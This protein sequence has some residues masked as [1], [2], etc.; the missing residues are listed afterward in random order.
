MMKNER[1]IWAVC[2]CVILAVFAFGCGNKP[3][4]VPGQNPPVE[5][6]DPVE[7]P[8]KEDVPPVA[9]VDP[10]E[11]PEEVPEAQVNTYSVTLYYANNEYI[12]TGNADLI[13]VIPFDTELEIPQDA[14]PMLYLLD[15]LKTVPG[16]ESNMA[17][18]INENIS[19]LDVREEWEDGV[20][21]YND[22][23]TPDRDEMV[24]CVNVSSEGLGGGSLTEELFITQVVETLMANGAF[25]ISEYGGP[26]EVQFLVDGQVADTLMGH[27]DARDT[28]ESIFEW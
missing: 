5:D 4:D 18:A 3:V 22:D 13:P 11:V 17:T 14:N 27:F 20:E 21:E 6:Q 1:L 9:P 7:T 15:A 25:Y 24:L 28:F 8:D 23:G 2:L 12:E 26:D 19:F 10:G 16:G